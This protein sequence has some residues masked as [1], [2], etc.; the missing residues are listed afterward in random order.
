MKQARRIRRNKRCKLRR[1]KIA[2]IACVISLF[3]VPNFVTYEPTGDN[4]FTISVNGVE[5]GTVGSVETAEELLLTARKNVSKDNDELTFMNVEMTYT[6]SEVVWGKTDSEKLVLSNME[7]VLQ[8]SIEETLSR[9]YL[10]KING[11]IVTLDNKDEVNSLLQAAI[12]KYDEKRKFT[13]SLTSDPSRELPVLIPQ[14]NTKEEVVAEETAKESSCY[15]AG[16][17]QD[18]IDT[19]NSVEPDVDLTFEDYEI[20][21][22]SIE[23]GDP[24]EVV[25]VYCDPEEK[26]PVDVAIKDV[27]EEELKN[28]VYVVVSG[29]T[30]SGIALKVGIPMEDIIAMNDSLEDTHSLIRPDDELIITVPEPKLAVNRVEEIYVEE[31]YSAPVEYIYNDEW[32]TTDKVVHQQP[33][34]GFHRAITLVSYINDKEI[35]SEVIKEEI[36]EGCEPVAKIVEV[37]TKVPPSYI[38]PINGGRLSSKFGYRSRPTK[39]ASTYH[40]GIDLATPVGTPVYAS[41]GGTV[42]KA[43]WGSG[44]GYV[45][46]INHPDGKQTRYGHLSKVLVSAGQTVSQGQK[47]ALSGNTGVSTGPHVHFEIL[48]NGTQVDPFRYIS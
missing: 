19:F 42:V 34:D 36:P 1:L 5:V 15:A 10:V 14:I 2:I 33:S 41:C 3:F 12:D 21:I 23:Y 6:G 11:Y 47:I 4:F 9:A 26:T 46:Y 7:D 22:V 31:G 45:V 38:R 35:E 8:N 44:Y 17:D 27:T 29:D 32:Y 18:M 40:K 24:I 30:L 48:V 20:G 13:V 25:E 16:F 28:D 37:G 43:G 39:G